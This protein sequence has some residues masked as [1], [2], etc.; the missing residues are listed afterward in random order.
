[1]RNTTV[2][3]G[4]PNPIVQ[5]DVT[6]VLLIWLKSHLEEVSGKYRMFQGMFLA[7]K[8]TTDDE[9]R[10]ADELCQRDSAVS[11]FLNL[12][13]ME[14][15]HSGTTKASCSSRLADILNIQPSEIMAMGDA[16]NDIGDVRAC[17]AGIA[18]EMPATTP[19]LSRMLQQLGNEE[20]DVARAIEKYICK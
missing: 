6:L 8:R 13:S 1:M 18:M 16:N 7:I 5:Y 20:E 14:Q 15:C 9:Q 19:N 2:L 12:L 11:S 3:G 17:W 4:K 10:F